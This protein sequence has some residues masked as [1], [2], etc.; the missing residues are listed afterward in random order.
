MSMQDYICHGA[1]FAFCS[2]GEK[3]PQQCGYP[4]TGNP[5]L[6]VARGNKNSCEQLEASERAPRQSC[7]WGQ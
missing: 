6:E 4:L 5:P 1:T 2:H 3:L 7:P